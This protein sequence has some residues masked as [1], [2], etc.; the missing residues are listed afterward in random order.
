MF[1]ALE[2]FGK[3]TTITKLTGFRVP[4]LPLPWSLD[5]FSGGLLDHTYIATVAKLCDWTYSVLGCGPA[6]VQVR[7]VGFWYFDNRNLVVG[8]CCAWCLQVRCSQRVQ[9]GV[10]AG[11]EQQRQ[12]RTKRHHIVELGLQRSAVVLSHIRPIGREIFQ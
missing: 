9:Q 6:K 12:H 3:F 10:E 8:L 2:K 7:D 5:H 1:L 11:E 4:K